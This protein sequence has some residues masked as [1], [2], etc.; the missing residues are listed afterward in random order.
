ME[1]LVVGALTKQATK[2]GEDLI[3][4]DDKDKKTEGK[5]V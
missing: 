1:K 4:K 5:P 2:Y 3:G